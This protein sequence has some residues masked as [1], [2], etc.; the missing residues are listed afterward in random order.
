VFDIGPEKLM[1]LAVVAV[2]LLGPE[3]LPSLARD[4]ARVL[5]QLR[6]LATGARTQ[7]A[8]E[9][10]PEFADVDLDALRELRALNARTAISRALSV[11]DDEPTAAPMTDTPTVRPASS[12]RLGRADKAPFDTDAT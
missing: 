10:G 8:D 3:R 4:L 12:R 11:E 7:L 6:Q 9:L 1:V 5:R 2:I